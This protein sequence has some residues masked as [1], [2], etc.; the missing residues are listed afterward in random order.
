MTLRN[1]YLGRSSHDIMEEEIDLREQAK[2]RIDEIGALK[3]D[4]KW[5]SK[6]AKMLQDLNYEKNDEIVSITELEQKWIKYGM[7]KEL[8]NF[9][10]IGYSKKI[11]TSCFRKTHNA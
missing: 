1:K 10:K 6:A 3:E 5:E 7:S 11:L 8:I 9:L 2:K 4:V